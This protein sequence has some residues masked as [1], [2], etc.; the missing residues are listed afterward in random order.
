MGWNLAPVPPL[1]IPSPPFPHPLIS[2]VASFPSQYYGHWESVSGLQSI[3]F[4]F[5][6]VSLIKCTHHLVTL[7]MFSWQISSACNPVHCCH[8]AA[9]WGS[10]ACSPYRE[11]LCIT[12]G[13]SCTQVLHSHHLISC[14]SVLDFFFFGSTRKWGGLFDLLGGSL[15]SPS[16][17][18]WQDFLL[19][20]QCGSTVMTWTWYMCVLFSSCPLDRQVYRLSVTENT[21]ASG[22]WEDSN[23]ASGNK[24]HLFCFERNW[25]TT[26]VEE[27]ALTLW[28]TWW[29]I[30]R[31]IPW[32]RLWVPSCSSSRLG[33]WSCFY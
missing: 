6:A 16:C 27:S 9:D 26:L 13:F 32:W 17:H 31:R 29:S 8:H 5:F 1:S 19:K 22:E 28:Q 4:S 23:L 11:G 30:I 15:A 12:S 25:N 14:H 21:V 18:Q 7:Q 3:V 20:A 2:A 24:H 10:W 33:N